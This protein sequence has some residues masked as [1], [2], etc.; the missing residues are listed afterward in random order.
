[1]EQVFVCWHQNINNIY[2]KYKL[3]IKFHKVINTIIIVCL[4]INKQILPVKHGVTSRQ[5]FLMMLKFLVIHWL[6]SIIRNQNV[7]LQF[8]LLVEMPVFQSNNFV[9]SASFLQ[10]FHSLWNCKTECF[11]DCYKKPKVVVGQFQQRW[12]LLLEIQCFIVR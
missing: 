10:H 8:K 3:P 9:H 12:W 7:R 1:M 5:I 4:L 2:Q 6:Y 11:N